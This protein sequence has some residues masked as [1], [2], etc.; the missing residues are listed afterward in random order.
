[1]SQDAWSQNRYAT[2][3]SDEIDVYSETYSGAYGFDLYSTVDDTASMRPLCIYVH[4][5]G[6]SQGRRDEEAIRRF[7]SRL[8]TYGYVVSSISYPLPQKGRGFGCD[9]S[10]EEKASTIGL[11]GKHVNKSRDYFKHHARRFNIDTNKIILIGSSAGAEAILHAA[12]WSACKTTLGLGKQYAALISM[13]GAIM[14]T[15]WI[16]ESNIIPMQLFHG[17]C[18]RLVP[19]SNAPH[20]YCTPKSA[21]YLFLHGAGSI[22][23]KAQNLSSGYYLYTDCGG[24]HEWYNKPM[25]FAF[26]DIIDFLYHDVILDK[27]RQIHQIIRSG[28]TCNDLPK[29]RVCSD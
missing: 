14:D 23:E 21:G 27:K 8:A 5:G 7:C 11:V 19:Y 15:E 9:V 20:H 17:T 2:P 4:G 1:M 3:I 28:K 10:H 25:T 12:Y 13:A 26:D 18:D 6:F 16:D 22:A 24:G 29:N